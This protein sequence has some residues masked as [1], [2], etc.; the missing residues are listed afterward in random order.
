MSRKQSQTHAWL[1]R[2]LSLS[3]I[4]LLSRHVDFKQHNELCQDVIVNI[5]N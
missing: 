2:I 5:F 4:G 1:W 3:F